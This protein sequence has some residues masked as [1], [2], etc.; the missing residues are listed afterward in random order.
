MNIYDDLH[1]G[2]FIVLEIRKHWNAYFRLFLKTVLLRIVLVAA[3]VI[4]FS[5][6]LVSSGTFF[7]I[8]LLA[9]VLYILG[10]WWWAYSQWIDEEFDCFI[11]TDE[12]LIDVTQNGLFS[13]SQSETNL[14]H[15][16][17]VKG[18]I[19]GFWNNIFKTGDVEIQTA[20]HNVI[21]QMNYIYNPKEVA[22]LILQQ[23]DIRLAKLGLELPT[24]P[25][26]SDNV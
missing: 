4:Y 15:I 13:I 20:A 21:F 16:Q 7:Q 11:L 8:L 26:N 25:A 5:K 2:E 24:H 23:R 10:M 14:D 17:D 3:V 22:H 9:S 19:N 1:T 12:R 18:R 6:L